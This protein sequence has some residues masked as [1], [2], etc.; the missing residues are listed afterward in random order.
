MEVRR[1]L[2]SEKVSKAETLTDSND[3]PKKRDRHVHDERVQ[4]Y[5]Q[6]RHHCE[7]EEEVPVD[8]VLRDVFLSQS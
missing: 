5:L 6:N 3:N 4:E 1:Q 8:T 2:R 7:G